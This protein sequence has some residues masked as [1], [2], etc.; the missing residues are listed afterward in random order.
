MRSKIGAKLS[1]QFPTNLK[2]KGTQFY[3]FVLTPS[4]SSLFLMNVRRQHAQLLGSF[5]VSVWEG[6]GSEGFTDLD[7][8]QLVGDLLLHESQP[9]LMGRVLPLRGLQHPLH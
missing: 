1:M 4:Y 2:Q 3:R 5:C 9:N 6:G 7:D 8:P